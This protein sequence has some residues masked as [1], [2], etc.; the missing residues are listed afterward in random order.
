MKDWK[1]ILYVG[2][3][4]AVFVVVKLTGPREY[5]WTIT[6]AEDDKNPYGGYVINQLLP[7]LISGG[8]VQHD[9]KS[10]YEL[11]DSIKQENLFILATTM[12]ADSSDSEVLLDHVKKGGHAFVSAN[13]FYGE[14][15]DRLNLSTDDYLFD[16]GERQNR[17]DTSWIK[18]TG[19]GQDSA[20][21]YRYRRD[22]ISNYFAQFDTTKTTVLARNDNGKPVT[23]KMKVGKGN[24][25]L[26][27]TPLAFTNIYMLSE[28]NSAFVS[29]TLSYLPERDVRWIAYYHLGRMESKTPLRFI[30][31]NE[32]LMWAYYI[33][34]FSI[35]LFMI[36]ESKRKQRI[37]PIMSPLQNTSLE[38]IRTIGNLYY[39]NG[40][41]K[42]LAEKKINYL[43]D[44]I[45]TR[46]LLQTTSLD[47]AFAGA[48]AKKSGK[49]LE[50]VS[51][52]IQLVNKIKKSSALS[53]TMLL[54][55]N[56]Q[57][58]KFLT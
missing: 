48:L 40:D 26:N 55:L 14:F 30:L 54:D 19:A 56:K 47:E 11:K 43:L 17:K 49:P 39:Q 22:N 7:S 42:N 50:E 28:D 45:R 8:N 34:I 37:I 36:F 41:H 24:L 27:C 32:P 53:E 6:F 38:F 1:Y 25:I 3:A 5:D 20:A 4:I 9:Y 44:L 51:A 13:Y 10:L 52:L 57:I 23:L 58:E 46:Y 31:T 29:N 15:A 35:L 2:L 33:T 21:R 16:F 12:S 18:F